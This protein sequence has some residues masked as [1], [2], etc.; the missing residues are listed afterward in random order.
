MLQQNTTLIFLDISRNH[1]TDQGFEIFAAGIG[2]NQGIEFLDISKNKDISDEG[3]LVTLAESIAKNRCLRTLDLSGI[4]LRKPYLKS[5]LEVALK[6]NITL[7]D[8]IGKISPD[9]LDGE[10]G[11]NV[12]IRDKIYPCF[13]EKPKISKRMP[14]NFTLVDPDNN[15]FL[16]IS[17]KKTSYILPSFK[18][19]NFHNVRAIDMSN[20]GFHDTHMIMLA[21]YL[22]NTNVNSELFSICLNDN[23]FT[24]HSLKIL[25]EA[26]KHN[27]KV[28]HLSILKCP[29]ITNEGLKELHGIIMDFNMVIF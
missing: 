14:F 25:A 15:S 24:D 22:Q 11:T 4:K 5:H 28:A 10:L 27:K 26:L 18:F 16:N 9:T 29:N 1:F 17:G 2:K 3:G 19:M 7:I 21:D 13:E 12:K 8:V 6:S 23:P 20:T